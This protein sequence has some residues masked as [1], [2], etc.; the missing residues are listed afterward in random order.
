MGRPTN[1]MPRRRYRVPVV[2]QAEQAECGLASLAMV[3]AY[4]G[5]TFDLATL[6]TRYAILHSGPTLRSI[7]SVANAIALTGRPVRLGLNELRRL[8]LPAILHWEFDHFVVMTRL[9]RKGV[10]VHDPA[11]GCRF[12]GRRE[13][14]D[15]FT[16]VAIEFSATAGF[17]AD[18]AGKVPLFGSLIRSFRGLPAFLGVMLGL[19]LVTQLLALAPPVATQL[20]IDEVVL[21]QDRRWLHKVLAGVG[22]IMITTLLID[23]LRRWIALYSGTRLAADSTTAVVQH[24]LRLPVAAVVARP[25]GDLLSRVDSLKP[26]RAALTETCLH[27]VVQLVVVVTTLAVMTFYSPRLMTLS[28]VALLIT[29]FLHALLLPTS[30]ALNLEGV[31]TSAQASNSLI[32]SLRSYR[33]VQALGLDA[34]RLAHWQRYFVAATN[35]GARQ[36]KLRIAESTGQGLIITVEYMLFLGIGIG[37]VVD[38]QITLG[39]LFAFLSLRGRL[40]SAAEQ[41]RSVVR[42]LFLLRSHV[43]RVGE[44]VTEAPQPPAR[45]AA[46]R[47]RI[48]GSIQCCEISYQYPGR[49]RLL[50]RFSCGIIAGESV[51]VSGPSGI[52]KST[53]LHL[54]SAELRPTGGSILVDGIEAELWDSR[55]LRR[56]FGIVLQQDRL[57][58][59]S[60][61]DNISSFEPAPDLGRIREA[62][63]LAAIWMDIQALPM[64]AHTQ[65]ADGGAALSG[66]Q[67]QRILI[68]R[69]LYRNPR[70][71]FLDEATSHL[72]NETEQCVLENLRGLDMTIV[73]VAHRDNALAR[74]GRVIRLDSAHNRSHEEAPDMQCTTDQ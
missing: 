63:C 47:R 22:C 44:L 29:M 67:V 41:M 36:G 34:Q 26:I 55:V 28:V 37:G 54:L 14:D 1:R 23:V 56:Q 46:I 59:G 40:N 38:K 24:L 4:F 13:L 58:Q 15:A 32:E 16:G 42:E 19:L 49:K 25:V 72:D 8:K 17:A 45:A 52:G 3:A 73:S 62:A 20:L 11:V 61:A 48:N 70:V 51:V 65:V 12:I 74:G 71:L 66:G 18:A 43:E 69:A 50:D 57:F 35:A 53:L 2:L 27:G 21:G 30:R 7:L 6:R 31:V 64:T 39:V 9:K 68:A 5:H 60:I 10:V 33:A